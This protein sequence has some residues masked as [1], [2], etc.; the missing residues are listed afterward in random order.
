MS[1]RATKALAMFDIQI[2]SGLAPPAKHG[3]VLAVGLEIRAKVRWGLANRALHSAGFCEY[4]I[5]F[6]AFLQYFLPLS[7][8]LSDY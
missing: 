8:H 3:D 6:L 5:T 1:A 2:R 4:N 7:I